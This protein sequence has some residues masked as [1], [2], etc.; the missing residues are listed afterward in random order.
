MDFA[1][2]LYHR[3]GI[4][5]ELPFV[6]VRDN[7]NAIGYGMHSKGMQLIQQGQH[8]R[9]TALNSMSGHSSID[10]TQRKASRVSIKVMRRAVRISGRARLMIKWIGE[11]YLE[12]ALRSTQRDEYRN[13]V[14]GREYLRQWCELE[15]RDLAGK[16]SYGMAT[17]KAGRT[18]CIE[19]QQQAYCD[20][21]VDVLAT[22]CAN[23]VMTRASATMWADVLQLASPELYGRER[24]LRHLNLAI[25]TFAN[26]TRG[27]QV[28]RLMS[29]WLEAGLSIRRSDISG[30]P[31]VARKLKKYCVAISRFL[32]QAPDNILANYLL[33]RC[34]LSLAAIC[35]GRVRQRVLI[36]SALPYLR[37]AGKASPRE[38]AVLVYLANALVTLEQI[39]GTTTGSQYEREAQSVLQALSQLAPN[40]SHVK[41]LLQ[42]HSDLLRRRAM[43]QHEQD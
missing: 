7:T 6:S 12:R 23:G 14:V 21:A 4:E 33:G 24:M 2:A 1:E 43:H 8:Y 10:S 39:E 26:P 35:N 11:M 36:E 27:I 18:H 34:L 13:A 40:S 22:C 30:V 9:R 3:V 17:L 38:A 41:M 31:I 19:S 5:V 29:A 25:R 37:V 15:P 16:L 32:L 42:V 20:E 28:D